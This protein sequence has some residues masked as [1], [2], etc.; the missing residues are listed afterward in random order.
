MDSFLYARVVAFQSLRQLFRGL[1]DMP[2]EYNARAGVLRID[3]EPVVV[4]RGWLQGEGLAVADALRCARDALTD[5][6]L[7]IADGRDGM[8]LRL[9][10]SVVSLETLD[11]AG[12][13]ATW[14]DHDDNAAHVAA[15]WAIDQDAQEVAEDITRLLAGLLRHGFGAFTQGDGAA[16]AIVRTLAA[17]V[18]SAVSAALLRRM[19]AG[20]FR[21]AVCLLAAPDRPPAR[22]VMSRWTA[23]HP[24][25]RRIAGLMLAE[26]E[27]QAWPP[28]VRHLAT[29]LPMVLPDDPAWRGFD[30]I[31][32]FDSAEPADILA[33]LRT[34]GLPGKSVPRLR[35]LPE[36]AVTAMIAVWALHMPRHWR[37]SLR[38]LGHLAAALGRARE[39][40]L[41][42][43]VILD[44]ARAAAIIGVMLDRREEYARPGVGGLRGQQDEPPMPADAY[45]HDEFNDENVFHSLAEVFWLLHDHA[46]GSADAFAHT[47]LHA[48]LE[49]TQ[50]DPAAVCAQL[51]DIC[52]WVRGVTHSLQPFCATLTP[53]QLG[54]RWPVVLR[55]QARWHEAFHAR[56]RGLPA[57]WQHD[58]DA[59][60]R[61]PPPEGMVVPAGPDARAWDPACDAFALGDLEAVPLATS[62][63]LEEEGRRLQH[64]VGGYTG[65]CL[66]RGHRVFSIRRLFD[67]ESLATAEFAPTPD[68]W[69]LVQL[70]GWRNERF[71]TPAGE[72]VEPWVDIVAALFGRL[73]RLHDRPAR[74]AA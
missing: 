7:R 19:P 38:W 44:A 66:Q 48:L 36:Q 60:R 57:E 56:R 61:L 43:P 24:F 28:P 40:D 2:W 73:A 30:G 23:Q 71:T 67:G 27:A 55:G 20:E 59:G 72:A 9:W 54:P 62:S 6:P 29:W 51:P 45:L 46:A 22:Q 74:R 31:A 69:R 33:W 52:D 49:D 3:D 35:Y 14:R 42:L 63:A 16:P 47:L 34:Q 15:Q 53:A 10:A 65:I 4:P 1:R 64:C 18:A 13:F 68:G 5:H 8:S 39:R 12:Y 58:I 11:E 21:D 17:E 26:D 70:R 37:H 32:H 25:M 50:A 41:P